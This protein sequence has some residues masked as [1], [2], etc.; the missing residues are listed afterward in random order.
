M[1]NIQL[2]ADLVLSGNLSINQLQE[3][4]KNGTLSIDITV[5]NKVIEM[6]KREQLLSQ[7]PYTI[8]QGKDGKWYTYL[9]DKTKGR[10]KIKRKHRADIENVVIEYYQQELENPTIKEVFDE[11]NDRRLRNEQ[12]KPSTHMRNQQLFN[13]CYDI[14]GS[15]RIKDVSAAAFSDFLEDQICVKKLTAK[16][17]SN[18]KS[19][20]IGFLKRAKKRGLIKFTINDFLDD[21]D[22]SD[23]SFHKTKKDDSKEVFNTSELP[24]L[25]DYLTQNPDIHNLGILLMLVTGIRVGELV[26]LKFEDF[27][28]A[29]TFHIHSTETR[30]Q[31]EKGKNHREISSNP[32]TDAGNRT[33]YIPQDYAWIYKQIRRI[34]PFTEYLFV[35]N[36]KRMSTDSIRKRM[37]RVCKKIGIP[38]RS[39]HK[40]RKTCAT[41]MID[42]HIPEKIIIGQLGHTNI[43]CTEQH[44][45]KD[46]KTAVEKQ[47]LINNIPEF[48]AN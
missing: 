8:Y 25:I 20:T 5:L 44:Y 41:I 46:R 19:I 18:L 42:N 4:V 21:L 30:Y 10:K 29:T 45:Y 28:D 12:I 37:Y 3:S 16:A 43:T 23:S 9:P 34:N 11:W 40:A 36:G 15:K 38:P 26:A 48:K 33:V 31:D 39:P 22:I 6:K 27:D 35:R 1:N 47:A 17:F 32:K 7:H 13:Q 2:L 14:F 24:I